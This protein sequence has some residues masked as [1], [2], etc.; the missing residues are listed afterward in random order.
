MPNKRENRLENPTLHA[1][2][3]VGFDDDA[4]CITILNSWGNSF[5]ND[6]YLYMQ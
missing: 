4:Q 2:L 1:V 5:G 3:V 6:G